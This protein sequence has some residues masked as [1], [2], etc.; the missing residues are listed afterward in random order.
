MWAEP[1]EGALSRWR[2]HYSEESLFR[3]QMRLLLRHLKRY[4]W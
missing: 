4:L 2:Y 1:I 3:Q